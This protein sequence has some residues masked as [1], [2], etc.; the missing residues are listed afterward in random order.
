VTGFTSNPRPQRTTTTLERPEL[1]RGDGDG[2]HRT[3][4][5][6]RPED[7]ESAEAWVTEARVMGFEVEALCG[8]TWIPAR[9]P[10]RYPVCE[11]CKDVL[12]HMG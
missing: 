11:A 9:D 4:I 6:R 3:H 1:Q 8:F 12:S 2:E 10:Q 7:R 5:V